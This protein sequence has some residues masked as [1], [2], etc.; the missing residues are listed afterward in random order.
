MPLTMSS[1]VSTDPEI[2]KQPVF[3]KETRLK[4]EEGIGYEFND[5]EI[6]SNAL[7]HR[8]WCSENQGNS[9]LSFEFPWLVGSAKQS[10]SRIGNQ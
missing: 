10:R 2:G 3:E 8:S 7:R 9:S 5:I 4:L 1:L 6:L